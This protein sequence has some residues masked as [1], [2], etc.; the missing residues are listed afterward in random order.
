MIITNQIGVPGAS[1]QAVNSLPSGLAGGDGEVIAAELHGKWYTAAL[2]GRLFIGSTAAAGTTIPAS[3][4][5]AATFMLYN[6]IGSA[7][8]LELVRYNLGV[9]NATLVVAAIQ[10]GIISGLTVAPTSVTALT[11]RSALV[12]G[13]GTAVGIIASVATLAA[14]ATSFY[15]MLSV[16]ATSGLGPNFT[17]DFDGSIVLTPGSLVH[18]TGT[19]AQSQAHAQTFLWA[20]WPA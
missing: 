10:L 11:S 2:N 19:A 14:A 13:T 17:H 9:N 16:S 18:V 3:N 15:H 6:P 1:R 8:N 7:K 4:A 5:T 12:G 20:E